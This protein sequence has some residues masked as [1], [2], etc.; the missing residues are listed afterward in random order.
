MSGAGTGEPLELHHKTYE[1]LGRERIDDLELLCSSCHKEADR[2]RASKWAA[3]SSAVL[4]NAGLNTYATKKYGGDWHLDL[5]PDL[6][7]EEFS[8]WVES[9]I[10]W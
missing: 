2:E 7:A 3:R 1:R 4:F 8:N 9:K 10:D 5:D 6:V